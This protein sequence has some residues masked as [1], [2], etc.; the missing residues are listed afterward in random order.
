MEQTF[1]IVET[2]QRYGTLLQV[3]TL[4]RQPNFD[5]KSP[6]LFLFK[7]FPHL[8]QSRFR[9]FLLFHLLLPFLLLQGLEGRGNFG[10]GF[11]GWACGCRCGVAGVVTVVRNVFQRLR[12]VEFCYRRLFIF[13][14]TI[15]SPSP[16]FLPPTTRTTPPTAC[17]FKFYFITITRHK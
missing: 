7:G 15:R 17:T 10:V 5:R 3:K 9:V 11:S 13:F 2:P 1:R 14:L 4:P 6:P 16:H 8:T 12:V